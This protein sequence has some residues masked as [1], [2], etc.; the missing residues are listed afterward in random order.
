[1]KR[2]KPPKKF[3]EPRQDLRRP[4]KP[5]LEFEQAEELLRSKTKFEEIKRDRT[6][7]S[8]KG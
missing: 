4:S 2:D 1:M 6:S 3:I 8:Y 5:N 7:R